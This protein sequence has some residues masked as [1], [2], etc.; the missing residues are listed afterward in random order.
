MFV[1]GYLDPRRKHCNTEVA[2]VKSA[3]N[4]PSLCRLDLRHHIENT[5]SEPANAGGSGSCFFIDIPHEITEQAYGASNSS[6]QHL[7]QLGIACPQFLREELVFLR[8]IILV[9]QV[10]GEGEEFLILPGFLEIVRNTPDINRAESILLIRVTGNHC[11]HRP[12]IYPANGLQHSYAVK[13]RHPL[14]GE[15]HGEGSLAYQCL[16]DL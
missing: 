3:H 11:T 7:L 5:I 10:P 14:I 4:L 12:G 13:S 8:K 9:H 6:L 16:F 1:Q 15:H 2:E